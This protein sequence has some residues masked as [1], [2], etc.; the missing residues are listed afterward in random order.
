NNE[1]NSDSI[2]CTSSYANFNVDPYA[3]PYTDPYSNDPCTD[4]YINSDAEPQNNDDK[5][6]STTARRKTIDGNEEE[7]SVKKI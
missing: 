2:P 3:N 5:L 7:K 6:C 1:Y 4:S